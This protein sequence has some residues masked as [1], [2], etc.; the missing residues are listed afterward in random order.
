MS[1]HTRHHKERDHQPNHESDGGEEEEDIPGLSPRDLDTLPIP[2]STTGQPECTEDEAMFEGMG[3]GLDHDETPSSTSEPEQE[4]ESGQDPKPEQQ[5]E[6][7]SG[8]E[9]QPELDSGSEQ[10]LALDPGSEQQP[11][12]EQDQ[13]P[14]RPQRVRHPLRVLTYNTLGQPTI[15][16]VQT[17]SNLAP[18]WRY[19][20]F[21]SPWMLPMHQYHAPPCYGPLVY[22]PYMQMMYA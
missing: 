10:Q 8:S 4:L 15:C 14:S 1:L 12:L 19:P 7:D 2:T 20:P 21:Q 17:G 22:S 6:L 18:G 16:S 11:E 3:E 9:Q 13:E 5:P